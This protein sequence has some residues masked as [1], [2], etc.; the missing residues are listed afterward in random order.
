MSPYAQSLLDQMRNASS[1]IERAKAEVLYACY[2]AR[3]GELE[4]A[5]EIRSRSR[6]KYPSGQYGELTVLHM[7]LDGIIHYF[8]GQ[9]T[10]AADRLKAAH[11]LASTFRFRRE[12]AFGAAWLAHVEFNRDRWASMADSLASSK[13][14]L[15]RSDPATH[16][17][18]SLVVADALLHAGEAAL[19]RKWYDYSRRLFTSIGDHA[20]IEAFL[21][22]SAALR[23]NAVRLLA[24]S[25]SPTSA[26]LQTLR[27]EIESA[28]NYQRLT[29]QKSFDY[30]LDVARA[31]AKVLE[32]DLR[33]AEAVLGDLVAQD[34]IPKDSAARPLVLADLALCASRSGSEE[35]LSVAIDVA[36]EALS[37]HELSSD[38]MAIAAEALRIANQSA[39]RT[40]RT[41]FW[42]QKRDESLIL[43]AD[44][45]AQLRECMAS[46]LMEPDAALGDL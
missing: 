5:G 31:S 43:F 17:R 23:L 26:Q 9:S 13:V 29:Q 46:W 35:A 20:A 36:E 24:I 42:L 40:E 7:C 16:G 30:L 2:W 32:N 15:E 19:S 11:A 6:A 27:G 22:N 44:T 3:V 34:T 25:Q 38:D 37:K 39:E 21:Y 45:Q 12:Q 18:L 14:A 8:S 1:E 28:A 4:V 41:V 10:A 33:G